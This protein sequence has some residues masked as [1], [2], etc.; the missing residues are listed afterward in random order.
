MAKFL[1]R[2]T[3]ADESIVIAGAF[4]H[5]TALPSGNDYNYFK[6]KK[7]VKN[8]LKHFNLSQKEME[9]IAECVAS[10]EGVVNP[11]TLEAKVVHDADVLEKVGLLGIIRHTWKMTNLKKINYKM[12]EDDDVSIILSHIEWRRKRMQT[13]I[14]KKIGK[15]LNIPIDKQKAKTIIALTSSMAFGGVVTEKISMTLRKHLNKKWNE[16]LREQLNLSYLSKFF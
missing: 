13:P 8:L 10:H 16:K 14:A 1:A 15:Y 12:I 3:G 11:K 9:G 7:V 5:D 2:K 6:N 4:L